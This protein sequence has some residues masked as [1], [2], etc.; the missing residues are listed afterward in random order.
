MINTSKI[1]TSNN[2]GEFK[3]V[4]Y[5]NCSN[6]EIEFIATG[7]K[8]K[9]DASNIRKGTIKD[10]LT[11]SICGAGFI[12]GTTYK[13]S[14]NG[15]KTKSYIT[16]C[17]MI[18]RCYNHKSQEKC[19]T[20]IGVAVCDEWHSYQ[21]F[22]EWFES[23]YIDGFHIDK[24]VKIKGNRVYSPET[25]MFI[26]QAQNTK[27]AHAKEYAFINPKGILVAFR[28]LADFCRRNGLT[29]SSMYNVN[30]GKRKTHKGWTKS[31]NFIE[32]A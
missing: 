12:G 14:V 27:E 8:T 2:H 25:C 21:N 32:I 26:S 6:I 28:D 24:D 30:S 7:Y 9:A 10:L 20:Y 19:P 29:K 17:N 1:Y 4:E 18:G 23:N 11:K 13:T 3:I 22:A 5:I 31:F 15:V 16:W